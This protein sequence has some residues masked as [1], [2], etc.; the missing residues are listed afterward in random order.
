MISTILFENYLLKAACDAPIADDMRG[1]LPREWYTWWVGDS[2]VGVCEAVC[3]LAVS[4]TA[5][6]ASLSFDSR[7]C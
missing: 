7:A 6:F 4:G 3:L 5:A 1:V 2:P